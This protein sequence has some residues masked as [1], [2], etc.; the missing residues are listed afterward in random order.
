MSQFLLIHNKKN[1]T[2]DLYRLDEKPSE[3]QDQGEPGLFIKSFEDAD[4]IFSSNVTTIT[5]PSADFDA[6]RADVS[7][8]TE[9]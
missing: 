5:S 9:K 1:K 2:V 6:P 8:L 4:V 7:V 3:N